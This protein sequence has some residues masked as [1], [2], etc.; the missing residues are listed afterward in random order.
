MRY[1]S[2]HVDTT[3]VP[4]LLGDECCGGAPCYLLLL[5]AWDRRLMGAGD[6]GGRGCRPAG[7]FVGHTEGVTHL[8]SKVG[9]RWWV[10]S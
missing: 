9:G 10:R 2:R 1:L 3:V 4:P 5:Q 8:D 7:V 6:G